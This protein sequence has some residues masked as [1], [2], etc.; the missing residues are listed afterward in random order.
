M[1]LLNPTNLL[2][3]FMSS[4]TND[5]SPA[6]QRKIGILFMLHSS[7]KQAAGIKMKQYYMLLL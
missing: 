4:E 7:F 6:L 2:G 3:I 5:P 1:H